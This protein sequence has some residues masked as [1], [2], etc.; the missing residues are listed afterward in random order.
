MMSNRFRKLFLR[1]TSGQATI[2]AALFLTF[3]MLFVAW[4]VNVNYFVSYV[5][6]IHIGASQGAALSAEGDLTDAGSTP[7]VAAVS[8]L[9]T[10]ETKNTTR[11]T[12][13]QAASINVCSTAIGVSGTATKCSSGVAGFIDPEATASSSRGQFYANAVQVTQQF[14][15][16]FSG[17]ILGHPIMPFSAPQTF[18]HTV[19]MRALN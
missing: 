12:R 11:N 6:T 3:M 4:T 10:S 15:P 18:T 7:A 1:E 16:F 13:E 17:T 5:K 14:T 8:A 9:A 2:E 19:Y